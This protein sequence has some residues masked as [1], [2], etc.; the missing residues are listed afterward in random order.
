VSA[1]SARLV[2][3]EAPWP[4]VCDAIPSV[5]VALERSSK[6]QWSAELL[7]RRPMSPRRIAGASPR[8]IAEVGRVSATFGVRVRDARL[9]HGWTVRELADRAGL[10]PDM[11]YR[12]EAGAPAS[13]LTATRLAIALER[14]LEIDLVDRRR[15]ATRPDLA[16][17][18]VHSAMGEFEAAHLRR[19]RFAVGIDEPYQHFQ[20]AGRGDV[21]A[22][23][24]ERRAFLHVENRTRF[25]DFQDMAGGFNAKRAYLGQALADR[26][27]V[28][29]WASETHVI[30]ALWS[31]EVLHALRLRR[32]S[33]RAL[34]PD[35]RANL[36]LWWSGEPPE[37]PRSS[38]LVVL[39]PL[40]SGRARPYCDLDAALVA[41]PR[42]RSY[43]ELASRL[44]RAA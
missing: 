35:D 30:A 31:S 17:D 40:A 25:P 28:R 26:I 34:C 38:I 42:Y 10:S 19:A 43:S 37:G 12:V 6:W 32:E 27:G 7:N 23:D 18:V 5:N 44:A 41:R 14:R 36:D 20:F 2:T 9:A 16:V 22:W 4:P 3:F 8:V 1:Q 21:V 15:R 29:R 13:S 11:V 33:F 24:G 39:D